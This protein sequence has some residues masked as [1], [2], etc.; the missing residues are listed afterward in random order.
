M[1]MCFVENNYNN[2]FVSTSYNFQEEL[3]SVDTKTN[4]LDYLFG[5]FHYDHMNYH[6]QSDLEHD[7]T[8][9]EMTSKALDVLEAN[10][11]RGYVL[12]VEGTFICMILYSFFL[13]LS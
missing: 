8:L 11:E 6:L 7:P 2:N 4:H 3:L 5:L 10:G 12:L 13:I 9:L 1:K